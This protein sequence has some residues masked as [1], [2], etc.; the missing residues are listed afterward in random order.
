M[1]HAAA[2][3]PHGPLGCNDTR[4]MA[5]ILELGVDITEPD[6]S[7][8][9]ALLGNPIFWAIRMNK[10]ANIKFLIEIAEYLESLS[11]RDVF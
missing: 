7:Q 5:R 1:V 11:P 2:A 4:L 9:T 10:I 8:R 6:V 3:D